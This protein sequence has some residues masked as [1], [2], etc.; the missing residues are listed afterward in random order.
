MKDDINVISLDIETTGLD[1]GK[2][3]PLSIGA[4]KL[5]MSD[6]VVNDLNSFYIQLE[7]DSLVVDPVAMKVNRL[8]IVDPPGD[9]D[10]LDSRSLPARE[11]IEAF[12]KWL[13]IAP[14]LGKSSIITM[15]K[16]IGSFD[17]PMLKSVWNGS[18]GKLL[19]PFSYRS[20]DLNTLFFVL[21]DLMDS[22]FEEIRRGITTIAWEKQRDQFGSMNLRPHHA[23]ADAW[24]N[25]FA[26]KECIKLFQLSGIPVA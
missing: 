6:D 17:L 10:S 22:S 3:V 16:N 21:A 9:H 20:I 5:N 4:V 14:W 25:V 19:W 12:Y 26:Y 1:V 2:H 23:L 7:W 13:G 8:N 15:G 11:G 24:W 18:H